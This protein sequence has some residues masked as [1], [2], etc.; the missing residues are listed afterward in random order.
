MMVGQSWIGYPGSS[1][2]ECLV[3][4]GILF[5]AGSL[6]VALSFW[7]VQYRTREAVHA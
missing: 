1:L 7:Y 2:I 6:W 4:F 5:L 3:V